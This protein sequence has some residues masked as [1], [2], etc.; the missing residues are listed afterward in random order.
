MLGSRRSSSPGTSSPRPGRGLRIVRTLAQ[1]P[2]STVYELIDGR[3]RRFALKLVAGADGDEA[4]KRFEAEAFALRRID[5]LHVVRVFDAFVRPGP[6]YALL[7]LVGPTLEAELARLGRFRPS[8]ARRVLLEV[9]EGLDAIHR[10]GLVHREISAEN[11]ILGREAGEPVSVERAILVDLGLAVPHGDGATPG[12]IRCK[13]SS[14]SPEQILSGRLDAR[15]DVYAAGALL[16]EL[17]TGAPPFVE[18]SVSATLAAHLERLPTLPSV[19]DPSLRAFD[20]L[21]DTA[22]AKRPDRRFASAADFARALRQVELE[23][24]AALPPS[25]DRSALDARVRQRSTAGTFETS[26]LRA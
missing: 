8:A 9:L 12:H 6:I 24:D 3:A 5:S 2:S 11:V 17:L 4:V 21:I 25:P 23:P 13:P 14:V 10:A 22:L 1:S 15:T 26:E 19:S 16:H 7:E 18:K 20:G